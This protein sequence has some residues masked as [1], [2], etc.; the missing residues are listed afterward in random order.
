VVDGALFVLL[1]VLYDRYAT[2][3]IDTYGGLATKLPQTATLFV[4][5]SLAMIGLPI[6]SGF[7]GEFLI[8]SSTFTGLSKG[9]AIA[10]SLGVILGAAYMLWLVQRLFYG[11]QSELAA[12]R[13]AADLDGRELALLW[14]LAVLMLVMGLAPSL[15]LPQIEQGIH[16]PQLSRSSVP[17]VP[18]RALN[19][20]Y[21]SPNSYQG[22]GQR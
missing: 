5:A 17:P 21:V 20:I 7:V 14:P 1:G 22:E 9:W 19:D 16:L 11:P 3:Q 2:S 18:I 13:P 8:L 12:S 6:L 15:W 10:A 4:I